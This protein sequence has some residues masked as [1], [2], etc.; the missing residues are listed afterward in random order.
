MYFL[1]SVNPPFLLGPIP[2]GFKPASKEAIETY[3]SLG[4]FYTQVLQEEHGNRALSHPQLP[5]PLVID[6]RDAARAHLLALTAPLSVEPGVGRKRI[7]VAGP[8]FMWRD[9][10]EHLRVSFPALAEKGRLVDVGTG[11][12]V[13]D[14]KTMRFDTSRAQKVLGL[15][16]LIPWEKTVDDMVASILKAESELDSEE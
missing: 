15:T 2:A 5:G 6:V 4:N 14:L 12:N 9:A 10:V 16:D 8:Q 1:V 13:R 3:S 11:K 7:L